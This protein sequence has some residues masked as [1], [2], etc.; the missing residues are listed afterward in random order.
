MTET[1]KI[2]KKTTNI[3]KEKERKQQPNQE[4]INTETKKDRKKR[5][6]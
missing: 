3:E 5:K 4:I 2:V 6:T 1:K